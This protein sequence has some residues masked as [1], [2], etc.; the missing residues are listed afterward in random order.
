MTQPQRPTDVEL[1]EAASALREEA[2]DVTVAEAHTLRRV[3][4]WLEGLVGSPD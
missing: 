3:A 4:D 2:G 1:R